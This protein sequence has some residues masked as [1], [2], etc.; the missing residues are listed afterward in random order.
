MYAMFVLVPIGVAMEWK[1]VDASSGMSSRASLT[2]LMYS[3]D[4]QDAR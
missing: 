2:A 4:P 1:V 3:G